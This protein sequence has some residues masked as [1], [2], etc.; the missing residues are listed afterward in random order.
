M[1]NYAVFCWK[2]GNF[3]QFVCVSKPAEVEY[4]FITLVSSEATADFHSGSGQDICKWYV[5]E[6]WKKSHRQKSDQWWLFHCQNENQGSPVGFRRN[7]GHEL[8]LYLRRT[9]STFFTSKNPA[10]KITSHYYYFQKESGI[11]LNLNIG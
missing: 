2:T 5:N 7:S 1:F 3:T 8:K 10:M 9:G 11:K 6:Q 4:K